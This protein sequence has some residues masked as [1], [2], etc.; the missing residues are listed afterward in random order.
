MLLRATVSFIDR[1]LGQR[2][3]ETASSSTYTS[4]SVD[5]LLR[6]FGSAPEVEPSTARSKQQNQATPQ[7]EAE[8]PEYVSKLKGKSPS[9]RLLDLFLSD[10]SPVSSSGRPE[11]LGAA[12]ATYESTEQQDMVLVVRKAVDNCKPLMRVVTVKKGTKVVY[13]PQPIEPKKQMRLA[14]KWIVEAAQK[15]K[16]S[17]ESKISECLALELLLAYQKKGS[18]REKRDALHKLAMDNRASVLAKWW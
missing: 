8:G 12:R 5:L 6:R 15:R 1:A 11:Q 2:V 3:L 9:G 16:A 4:S 7:P 13:V 17:T 10:E 18:A 14:V